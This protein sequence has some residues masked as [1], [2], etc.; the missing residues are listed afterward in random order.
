V[1]AGSGMKRVLGAQFYACG[2][3]E[4]PGE[5]H[6]NGGRYSFVREL[7]HDFF[8]ATGLYQLSNGCDVN[9][10]VPKKVVLKVSRQQNLLGLPMRWLGAG[11]CEREITNIRRV[12]DLGRVPR[13]LSSYG[14]CGMIYEYIEGR[15]LDQEPELSEDFFE[16][17]RHLLKEL[18]R[19]NVVY[20]DMNKRDNVIVGKDGE[21]YLIDFQISVHVPRR[22]LISRRLSD[23]LL[24]VLKTADIYHLYKLKRK[25][26]PQYLTEQENRI[27]RHKTV[28][29][30]LHRLCATPFRKFQRSFMKFLRLRGYLFREKESD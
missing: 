2:S 9:G 26:Q 8:A 12:A 6:V 30:K 15:G 27:S 23:R 1:F 22:V 13:L 7:K 24:N 5:I 18:H 10:D 20:V 25:I 11:I 28:L 14:R 16:K 17:L 19:R 29:I 21:P 4:L 3:R